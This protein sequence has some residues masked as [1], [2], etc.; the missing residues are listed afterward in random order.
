MLFRSLNGESQLSSLLSN[1]Q[2][3]E[4]LSLH[5]KVM[6]R[7]N[8]VLLFLTALVFIQGVMSDMENV[9]ADGG[10]VRSKKPCYSRKDCDIQCAGQE[11]WALPT[12]YNAY[13]AG[14]CGYCE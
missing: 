14:F 3:F 12:C 11:E 4:S 5:I 9:E 2:F 1:L 13:E 8:C 10:I 6:A 7:H